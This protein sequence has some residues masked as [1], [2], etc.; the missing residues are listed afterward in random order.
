[1]RVS[2][3]VSG[4]N[5][6][7]NYSTIGLLSSADY[8]EDGDLVPGLVPGSLSNDDL[9]WEKSKQTDI[10]VDLGLFNNR[11]SLTADIYKNKK[12]DLLLA[13][14]LPA[15]SGYSSSTQNV[16][17]IEN[18]GLELALET[19]NIKSKNFNWNSNITFSTN[20]NE[21]SKLATEGA[22]ISNSSYQVTQVGYPIAS[23]YMLNAIGVFQNAEEV[24]NSALQSSKVQPGDLK[25]ED[26]SGDGEDI[27]SADKKI[28]GD[29]WPDYTW[30]FNN[31]FSYKNFTLGI[32]INGSHGADTYYLGG[33]ITTNS[34]GVQNQLGNIHRWRS[35][36]DP[37]DG[38][39]PR[40]IR[41]NYAY[42][43]STSSYYLYDASYVRIKNINLSYTFP[44]ELINRI[45]L[46]N[47]VMYV[48]VA[49]VYTFT[50]YPG[51]DPDGSS[52][53]NQITK[54]GI[55]QGTFPLSRTYTFG[56]KLSF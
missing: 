9:T 50:D 52:T 37:G 12:T 13:V 27:T 3:G 1:M 40:A 24:A 33:V 39:T 21:V 53:G 48:D 20:K 45:A 32:A 7:G 54:S 6:I 2:Y 4:N 26:V 17:D 11:I 22:M 49:N 31:N 55:D 23:F 36:S 18:K 16:G 44:R 51:Y 10:G 41:S 34:A 38:R 8:V 14:E 28:V 35:E 46:S 15:A 43:M 56:V 47:L 29:P 5:Q 19:V 30:G 42:S 25:F